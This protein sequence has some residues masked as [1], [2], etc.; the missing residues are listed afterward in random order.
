[1]ETVLGEAPIDHERVARFVLTPEGL[2][3]R[4]VNT[5]TGAVPVDRPLEP[6]LAAVRQVMA[7]TLAMRDKI[8]DGGRTEGALY[9]ISRAFRVGDRRGYPGPHVR[10]GAPCAA[11]QGMSCAPLRRVPRPLQ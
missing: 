2:R 8:Y 1:M 6:T 3:V 4:F 11:R 9:L 7:A 10:G 5:T